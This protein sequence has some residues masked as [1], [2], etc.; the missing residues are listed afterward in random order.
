MSDYTIDLARPGEVELLPAIERRAATLFSQEDLAPE[1][2][3]DVTPLPVYVAAQRDGRVFV[4]RDAADRLVGF[5]HLEWIDG[6]AYLE[7]LDVEPDSG[8]RGIGRCLVEAA[9]EW[10]RSRGSDRI[11]LSTFRDVAWNAPFYA[12]LGFVPIPIEA[13]SHALLAL[14]EREAADGL[15]PA[16]RVMMCRFL[17][18]VATD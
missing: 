10:A 12:R 11:T 9:C 13:L 3:A 17:A 7:E 14:R 5:A 4:A 15:D 6:I 2:A 1:H 16:K 8:R 18:P